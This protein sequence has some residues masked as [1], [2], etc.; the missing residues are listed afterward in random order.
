[1]RNVAPKISPEEYLLAPLSPQERLDATFRIAREAF[2][3][4]SLTLEDI[5]VAVKKVRRRLYAKRQKATQS[6]R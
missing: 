5:E 2:K 4:K 1:M 6:R 3:N